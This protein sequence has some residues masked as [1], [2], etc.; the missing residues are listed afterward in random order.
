V[1]ESTRNVL[2]MHGWRVDRAAHNWV[3]FAF[4]GPYVRVFLWVGGVAE[5][6]LSRF[7]LGSRIFGMVFDRYHAKI[8]TMD[9]ATKI[10]TLNED[11]VVGPDRTERIIPFPYARSIILKEPGFIAVM[12]CPCRLAREDGCRPVDVC[13]A[14]GR[15]T[16]QFW[17]EHGAKYNAR[18][19][20]QQEA[21]SILR[22]AH[23][24]GN[25]TTSWFKVATGG[26]TGVICACCT[27]CCGGLEGMRLI[28]KFK[29]G[30]ELSN[31]ISSGY[32]AVVDGGLCQGC[33]TCADTCFFEAASVGEGG[34]VVQ[35][36][37]S[38]MGCGL[39]VERCPAGARRLQA[40]LSKGLPLDID[41]VRKELA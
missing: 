5:R 10:L 32:V 40:D 18:K 29:G 3:Y 17:L 22:E 33:G 27:C 35:S 41:L 7:T 6:L 28:K 13:L 16:A 11:V 15:T 9:D 1:K 30:E 4:Y 38:C 23:D 12:D 37:Q 25:I 8:L 2:K 26:R 21:L 34:T 19:I 31:I 36:A 14:V 39:C 24:R 20:T